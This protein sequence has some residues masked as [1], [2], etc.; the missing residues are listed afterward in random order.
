MLKKNSCKKLLKRNFDIF[1]RTE[2][3][4]PWRFPTQISPGDSKPFMNQKII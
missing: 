4:I 3:E 1:E 2:K